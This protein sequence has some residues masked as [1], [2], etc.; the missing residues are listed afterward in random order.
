MIKYGVP[1]GSI[2]GPLLFL[3]YINDVS[4]CTTLKLVSFADDT[5][6]YSSGLINDTMINNFNKELGKIH[7]WLCEN[8]LLLNIKKT[9]FMVFGPATSR[10]NCDIHIAIDGMNITRVGEQ[11]T[12][13]SIKFL[14]IIL[15]EQ[16]SWKYHIKHISAKISKTLFAI[17]LVKNS[18]PHGA[19]R[20]L[21]HALI[22]SHISYGLQ[23]WGNATSATKIN[24]L[25]KK[26]IRIVHRKPYRAHTEPL[27]KCCKILKLEDH[28]KLQ[29]IL[30][31]YDFKHGLLPS[32]FH[33]F[34]NHPYQVRNTRLVNNIAIPNRP[35]TNFSSKSVIHMI[36]RQWNNLPIDLQC[37]SSHNSL[38]KMYKKS[39]LSNYSNMH[40]CGDRD[41]FH[42]TN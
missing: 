26:A 20:T 15:D 1:Q 4:S 18:L 33:S 32:S 22:Q 2:L 19:L 36:P 41:C 21:Y 37:A 42:C 11:F 23:I 14:G 34:Y 6:I 30:F 8:K 5:T 9:K 39:T 40:N 7:L 25:Q 24:I 13:N 27:F 10:N 3:L 16:L 12:E 31:A 35:R 38:V 29:N 17:N 28:Y